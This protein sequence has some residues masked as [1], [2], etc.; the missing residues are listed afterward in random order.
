[1]RRAGAPIRRH[2]LLVA[3]HTSWLDILILG[4]ATG[5]AFVSKDELGHPFV[6]WLADQNDTVYVKRTHRKAGR[7]PGDRDCPALERDEA[8]RL[9]PRRHDGSGDASAAVSLDPARGGEFRG[10]GRRDPPR[11]DR[12]WRRGRRNRLVAGTGQGQCPSNAR[13]ARAPCRSRSTCLRRSTALPTA[14]SLRSRRAS[15]S[16]DA[17]GFKSLGPLAYRRGCNDSQDFQDQKL[18][19]PD[20]R[21]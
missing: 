18:R 8:R 5:C 14:S 10:E 15:K 16:L 3:N 13:P 12:L 6:H 4:G 11:R 19:L 9:I 20:E 2:T 17:L 21:L 7:G 1:M